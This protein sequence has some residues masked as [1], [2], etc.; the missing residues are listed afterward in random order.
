VKDQSAEN[1]PLMKARSRIESILCLAVATSCAVLAC[2]RARAEEASMPVRQTAV[3]VAPEAGQA[4]AADEQ[5]VYAID[6]ALVAKYSRTSGERLA[7]STG[8]AKHLNSGFLWEGKLYCAHSNYPKKPEHSEVKVLDPQSMQLTTFKD[9]GASEGS[10]TWVVRK[11]DSWWC[12][13]A[14]YGADNA[15][16]RL[17]KFDS[18]WRELAAWTYPAEVVQ[19]LGKY[20]ISGGIWQGDTLLATGHDRRVIY[21]LRLPEKGTVLELLGTTASPFPG[22]G[23]AADPKS[24]GLVGIDRSKKQ[25][26]FAEFAK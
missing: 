13:F 17:V 23:I 9:F 20:S 21:R 10:L 15:K 4:A 11:G 8:E 6:T 3:L 14:Y 1:L 26:V 12:T 16:T 7:V 24:G 19:E 2:F 25:V 22:Q 5:F 18:E